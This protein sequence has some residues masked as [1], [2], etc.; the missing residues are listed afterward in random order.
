MAA[1]ALLME[2]HQRIAALNVELDRF[3]SD[4]AQKEQLVVLNKV[5]TRPDLDEVASELAAKLGQQHL[6][7]ISGVSGQGLRELENLLLSWLSQQ[8]EV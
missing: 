3:S 4:L 7:V 6:P 8:E 5:D 2:L 1:M